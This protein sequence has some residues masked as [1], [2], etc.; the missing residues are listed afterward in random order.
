[1]PAQVSGSRPLRRS[2]PPGRPPQHLSCHPPRD[3]PWHPTLPQPL[4]ARPQRP[5]T[6][7]SLWNR[8]TGQCLRPRPPRHRHHRQHPRPHLLLQHR[9]FS[10]R[11][12]ARRI[13]PRHQHRQRRRSPQPL[14]FPGTVRS[15]QAIRGMSPTRTLSLQRILTSPAQLTRQL[16]FTTQTN[17]YTPQLDRI[18]RYPTRQHRIRLH[19]ASS[20]PDPTRQRLLPPNR[21]FPRRSHL[22]QPG[23][24][25]G[26]RRPLQNRRLPPAHPKPLAAANFWPSKQPTRAPSQ[27]QQTPAIPNM[28]SRIG[29]YLWDRRA[30]QMWLILAG[31]LCPPHPIGPSQELRQSLIP[32]LQQQKQ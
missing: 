20:R 7:D 22:L 25:V 13:L 19:R 15:S 2:R 30:A 6:G 29:A 10:H 17:P 21:M 24:R 12:P 11:Y 26:M 9:H 32:L 14:P 27:I 3:L 18:R 4:P 1:M 31:A 8:T 28:P 5:M 23:L 16:I